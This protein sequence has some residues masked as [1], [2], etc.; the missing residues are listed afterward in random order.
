MDR[1]LFITRRS[2]QGPS[3]AAY[4]DCWNRTV[5]AAAQADIRAWRYRSAHSGESFVEFLEADVANRADAWPPDEIAQLRAELDSYG[6]GAEDAWTDV[7]GPVAGPSAREQLLGLVRERSLR[8]GDFVL[9]S[10][11]RSS[12][13][14]DARVTTMSG[15]GQRLI[16]QVGLDLLAERAW[17]PRCIGGLTLGAD[18]IA[19]A[20]A[21]AAARRNRVIDAFTVRKEV[22]QHGTGRRIEGAFSVDG[23]VVIVEDVIT[24]GESALQAVAVVRETG[25]TIVGVLALVDRMEGG[26]GRIESEGL[27]VAAVFDTA[28]LLDG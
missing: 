19:Y 27:P 7:S 2:V 11:A 21:H 13:Y 20:I 9:S 4:D 15:E 24:S 22:K 18:P 26:K 6:A 5:M 16:G 14:I 3:V 17:A 8:R 25:A 10:G 23:T 1:Q 28:E 12:Y